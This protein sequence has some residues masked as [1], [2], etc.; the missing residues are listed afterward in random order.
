M[1]ATI[2]ACPYLPLKQ[3]LDLGHWKVMPWHQFAEQAPSH[4]AQPNVQAFRNAM[5]DADG[6]EISN[7]AIIVDANLNLPVELPL[8]VLWALQLALDLAVME[9][10]P[11]YEPPNTDQAQAPCDGTF[12]C[13][14]DNSR[15]YLVNGC[16]DNEGFSLE[17][18]FHIRKTLLTETLVAPVE[19]HIRPAPMWIRNPTYIATVF[20]RLREE[21]HRKL[22][23]TLRWLAKAW[24]NTTALSFEDRMV[25]IKTGFEA[26]T[27]KSKTRECASKLK[28]HFERCNLKPCEVARAELLWEPKRRRDTLEWTWKEKGKTKTKQVT[29]LEHW[30]LCFG[31]LRNAVIHEGKVLAPSERE[32]QQADS[33]YRGDWIRVGERILREAIRLELAHT[34][35]RKWLLANPSYAPV[36]PTLNNSCGF[37]DAAPD[38]CDCENAGCSALPVDPPAEVDVAT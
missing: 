8:D 16:A 24:Q 31:E 38:S 6:K 5:R 35:D 17:Q 20:E 2:V 23:T 36:I 29:L 37:G 30:V 27:G 10:F 26:F 34:H 18:G 33:P 3:V 21:K 4:A 15:I 32:Y 9:D 7:P 19:L 22:A 25:M 28:E 14:T 13:T 1:S 12:V 11:V